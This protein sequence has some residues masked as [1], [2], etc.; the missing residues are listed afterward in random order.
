MEM[1]RCCRRA[2]STDRNEKEESRNNTYSHKHSALP[3]G[4][5]IMGRCMKIIDIAI[6][7]N[8]LAMTLVTAFLTVPPKGSVSADL[9]GNT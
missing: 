2:S 1:G 7:P 3:N 6:G 5:A 9:G 4:E 8:A